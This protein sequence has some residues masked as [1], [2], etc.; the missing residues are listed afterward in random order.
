M[1]RI[2][3]FV[4]GVLAPALTAV[5][6]AAVWIAVT[7]TFRPPWWALVIIS[8]ALAVLSYVVET[9]GEARRRP[10]GRRAH[11]RTTPTTKTPPGGAA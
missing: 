7:G 8:V 11:A 3:P 5:A 2:P 9:V 4:L 1:R 6:F 10:G